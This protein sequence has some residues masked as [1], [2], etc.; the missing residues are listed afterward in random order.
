MEGI[1]K[2]KD[3]EIVG[4]KNRLNKVEEQRKRDRDYISK[5]E[6]EIESMSKLMK[7]QNKEASKKVDYPLIKKNKWKM[8]T[9]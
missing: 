1:I 5:L 4:L 7:K 6:F 9:I 8:F 2:E 3:A